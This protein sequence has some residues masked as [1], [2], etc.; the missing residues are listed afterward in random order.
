M[1]IGH[2][3]IGFGAK[4]AEPKVS[5]GTYFL[6]AQFLD[7]VWPT[8]LI[9]GWESVAIDPGNTKMTPLNFISYP[10]THSLVMA[11][12]WSCVVG[13]I[14]WLIKK[15]KSGALVL[16]ICVLSHWILDLLVHR[17][18]L[19]LYPGESPMFGFGLWN[20]PIIATILESLIF[21]IG[22]IL[23]L[24]TTKAKNNT[25]KYAFWSL[26]AF[27]IIIQTM[28]MLG[29]PP[30]DVKSIAIAGHLQW[31]FVIWAYWADRNREAV[32]S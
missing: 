28:N 27:L 8:F 5:L 16:G 11:M 2:F 32:H 24:R 1:F 3:A 30:P 7:L 6:A 25:G 9:L 23:Y 15:N 20:Y 13:I 14:Y 18:D 29:P 19:P 17:P 10:Y 12:I 22:L 31:L 4:S 26:V 21:I